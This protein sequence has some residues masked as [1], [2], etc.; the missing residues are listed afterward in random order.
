VDAGEQHHDQHDEYEV[1]ATTMNT[2][3]KAACFIAAAMIATAAHA[4]D[5]TAHHQIKLSSNVAGCTTTATTELSIKVMNSGDQAQMEKFVDATLASG[6]CAATPAGTV[7]TVGHGYEGD[8]PPDTMLTE[9][10]VPGR[11]TPLWVQFGSVAVDM[12]GVK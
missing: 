6:E 2:I 4:A 11:S 9:L 10:I 1:R 12:I 3:Y 7:V 5:K 8:A